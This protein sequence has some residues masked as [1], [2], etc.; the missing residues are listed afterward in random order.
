MRLCGCL[1]TITRHFFKF[2]ELDV[3][4]WTVH[5]LIKVGSLMQLPYNQSLWDLIFIN[6]KWVN[7]WRDLHVMCNDTRYNR[8][9][10]EGLTFHQR[11][12]IEN[13]RVQTA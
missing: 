6:H 10:S 9:M 2:L 8:N 4:K 13:E 5:G 1:Y 3:V 7:V 12:E 11:A